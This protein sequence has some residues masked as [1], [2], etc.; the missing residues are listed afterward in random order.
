LNF[1]AEPAMS[2]STSWLF[3]ACFTMTAMSFDQ[4]SRDEK[5]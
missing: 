2:T 5:A 3:P 1:L 4:R